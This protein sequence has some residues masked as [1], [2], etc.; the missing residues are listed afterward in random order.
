MERKVSD[1]FWK[2]LRILDFTTVLILAELR[3]FVLKHR[4]K[5]YSESLNFLTDFTQDYFSIC[6][7]F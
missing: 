1:L 3:R 2:E 4:G 6:P 5:L 7:S